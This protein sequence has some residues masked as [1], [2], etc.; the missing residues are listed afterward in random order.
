[1]MDML[2]EPD[3]DAAQA[4]LVEEGKRAI[5]NFSGKHAGELCSFFAFCVDYCYGDVVIC[6]DTYDNGLL[7]AKRNEVQ[8][9]KIWDDAFSGER[10][11]ANARSYLLS[12]RLCTYNPHTANFK[13]PSFAT[14]HLSDWEEYI[15]NEQRPEHPDPLGHV[16]VLMY[17]VISELVSS[18]SFEGLAL[19]TP[20]R[21]GVEFAEELGLVVMRLLNWPSHQGPRV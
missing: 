8:T 12:R 4:L 7:H 6:F 9:L 21:I 10:G 11:A 16:I 2:K 15:M 5:G 17:R 1:M 20:F 18:R 14:V 3:W 19:S 13:Y